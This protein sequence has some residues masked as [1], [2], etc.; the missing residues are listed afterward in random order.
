MHLQELITRQFYL[1]RCW[2]EQQAIAAPVFHRFTPAAEPAC[3]VSWRPHALA[4]VFYG[5]RDYGFATGAPGPC[6]VF[7]PSL[8][9]SPQNAGVLADCGPYPLILFAHGQCAMDSEHY[10]NWFLIPAT[11]ARAG[12]V[13]VVPEIKHG[14]YPTSNATDLD[15]LRRTVEWMRGCWRHRSVLLPSPATG[16]VG[17][18]WGAVLMAQFAAEH[19][20]SAFAALSG[21]WQEFQGSL[22]PL[23][24]VE[25]PKLFTWG[26]GGFDFS[27]DLTDSQWAAIATPKHKAVFERAEHWD[28]L[29]TGRTQCELSR[30]PC[31]LT[32]WL[33][34]DLV[35]TF[36]G[37]YLGQAN[38]PA[39]SG[40]P[41][42]LVPPDLT[43]TS[44]Q[45]FYAG[46]FLQSFSYLDNDEHC[47]VELTWETDDETGSVDLPE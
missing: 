32:P 20:V 35:T 16:V 44:E 21:T 27:S 15:R 23:S 43:L 36:F 39:F 34:M 12:Y 2:F 7:F 29:P 33:A 19:D 40:I 41:A 37:K 6:R 11:L 24:E 30:G 8:D 25:I 31:G 5:Y 22:A 1:F 18:S 47:G 17:H 42:S 46:G 9:G 14:W 4:P 10:K 3:P 26:E 13:V 28:Y 45:E 38:S